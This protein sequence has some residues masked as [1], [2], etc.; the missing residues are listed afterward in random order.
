[1]TLKYQEHTTDPSTYLDVLPPDSGTVYAASTRYR[2]FQPRELIEIAVY[3]FAVGTAT[4]TYTR[5]FHFSP[6]TYTLDFESNL[7]VADI[8][9]ECGGLQ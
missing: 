2:D 1:M 8:V 7:N 6:K 5:V 3:L 4:G 9:H